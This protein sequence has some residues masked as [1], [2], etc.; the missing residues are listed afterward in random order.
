MV[1]S[2]FGVNVL[3]MIL[4]V[5]KREEREWRCVYILTSSACY[6]HAVVKGGSELGSYEAA[7]DDL[8]E[9]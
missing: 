2:L 6:R 7:G 1:H 8:E 3:L 9:Q 5:C 4:D